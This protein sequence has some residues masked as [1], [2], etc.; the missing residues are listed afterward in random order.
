MLTL[1]RYLLP[2]VLIGLV[3]AAALVGYRG[4]QAGYLGVP[5]N[6]PGD[7]DFGAYMQGARLIA[8]GQS[9]YT[10]TL[11][12]GG[13]PPFNSFVVPEPNDYIYP[14]ALAITLTPLTALESETSLMIWMLLNGVLLLASAALAIM[15]FAP[16]TRGL[17]WVLRFVLLVLLFYF[18]APMQFVFRNGQADLIILFAMLL[19]LVLYQRE[20]DI[21]AGVVLSL[22]I[23]IKPTVALL[24]LFFLWKRRWRAF[25]AA[26]ISSALLTILSF[27]LLGLETL[28]EYLTVN[29]WW[30]S[31]DYL[32]FP[33]NQA[34]TAMMLRAFSEN[35][36]MQPLAPLPLLVAVVPLLAA[37]V[38]MLL[39]V[40]LVRRDDNYH[41]QIG[42]LEYGFTILTMM[43]ALPVMQ[44]NH[45][46]WV[47]LPVAGWLLVL[48]DET[49]RP[50]DGIKLLLLAGIMLVL[51][52]PALRFRIF[53][54]FEA[55]MAGEL[56]GSQHLFFSGAYLY[57]TAALYVFTAIDLMLR[58]R[59][60]HRTSI[61]EPASMA[62]DTTAA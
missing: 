40:L 39:W 27:L 16:R 25:F 59:T 41:T 46:I 10:E 38:V 4:S 48:I 7:K 30:G 52:Y 18:F 1:K 29:S 58:R 57:A 47:L 6:P 3:L 24:A 50:V 54:G 32:A 51:G 53:S 17:A 62:P 20:Q 28:G 9:P 12:N 56:V 2:L 34:V 23:I 36:Y 42:G 8:A 45:I 61:P 14:P 11:Q 33:L 26:G 43:L 5:F 21:Q 37:A 35:V 60:A 19:A 13:V 44:D 22:A 15:A 55:A 49:E 31:G